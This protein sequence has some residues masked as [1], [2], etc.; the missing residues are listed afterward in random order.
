MSHRLDGDQ[1]VVAVHNLTDE[2][3]TVTLDIDAD[4]VPVFSDERTEL[5]VGESVEI[6]LCGYGYGW[7]RIGGI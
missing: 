7:Y 2:P 1:D 4:I 5:T 6:N 3:R